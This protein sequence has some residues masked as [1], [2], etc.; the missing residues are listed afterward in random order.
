MVSTSTVKSIVQLLA[1]DI[2]SGKL[3]PGG[4]RHLLECV[5]RHHR[6]GH[7][8]DRKRRCG[9]ARKTQARQRQAIAKKYWVTWRSP[10]TLR[11]G[12]SSVSLP[13]LAPTLLRLRQT[14]EQFP[15]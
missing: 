13:Q 8:L 3:Q 6:H 12:L 11:I 14:I 5:Q 7:A 2:Q 9:K 4:R 15:I 1:A 10:H